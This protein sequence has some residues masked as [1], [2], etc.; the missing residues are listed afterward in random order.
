M[1]NCMTAAANGSMVLSGRHK[2]KAEQR[3]PFCGPEGAE[4]QG[5][6]GRPVRS[7]TIMLVVMY[8]SSQTKRENSV[9]CEASQQTGTLEVKAYKVL[10]GRMSCTV[11]GAALMRVKGAS[12]LMLRGLMS[13]LRAGG[14]LYWESH[15]CGQ[16]GSC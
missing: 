1:D 15:H 14:S 13:A 9:T 5:E 4:R 16:S 11:V 6:G 2:H 7:T 12:V 8:Q 10:M 3:G